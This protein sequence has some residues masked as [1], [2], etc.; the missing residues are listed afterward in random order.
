VQEDVGEVLFNT[1]QN[2]EKLNN[3]KGNDKKSKRDKVLVS[4]DFT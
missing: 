1:L 2:I 4:V 3:S